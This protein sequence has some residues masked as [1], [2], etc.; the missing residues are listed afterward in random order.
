MRN[1]HYIIF[2]FAI[3]ICITWIISYNII[4]DK[5][6][7]N[8][9]TNNIIRYI[10]RMIGLNM[11]KIWFNHTIST[12]N[13][14][15]MYLYICNTNFSFCNYYS[16]SLDEEPKRSWDPRPQPPANWSADSTCE[17]WPAVRPRCIPS[18]SIN[19]NKYTTMSSDNR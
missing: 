19:R 14:N 8:Y 13:F 2:Y 11:L 6:C 9:L 1:T 7:V 12:Y 10:I 3:P 5:P 15:V 4:F 17:C 16:N 18:G